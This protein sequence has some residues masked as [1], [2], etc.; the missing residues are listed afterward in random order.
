[1][2]GQGEAIVFIHSGGF[3]RRIWERQFNV[4][5]DYYRALRYNVRGYGKSKSPTRPYS[6]EEDLYQLLTPLKISK[7]YL[8]GMSWGERITWQNR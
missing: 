3:D 8:V 7:A 5:A 2:K 4:F 1:M 6:D